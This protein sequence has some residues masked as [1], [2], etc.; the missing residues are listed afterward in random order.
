M[1]VSAFHPAVARW[2]QREMGQPTV[3][4]TLGWEEISAGRHTLIE[5]PT[6]S[7]KTLAAFM[8]A[9]NDLVCR[10]AT[11]PGVQVLYISPLKALNNDIQRNLEA[12]LLGI[13]AA[14]S[15]LGSD[16]PALRVDVRTGDTPASLRARQIKNPPHIFIT[17]PE[18]LYLLL[19]AQK[20]QGMFQGLRYVVL[21]EIHAIAGTKRG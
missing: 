19:T 2:F 20:S 4:Q 16:L 13:Q 11:E 18:S 14:A 15:E 1:D 10:P 3:A 5:A 7:G 21:D 9:L 8:W 6:G 17:T 12:P